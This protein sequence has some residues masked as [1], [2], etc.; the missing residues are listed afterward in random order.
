MGTLILGGSGEADR[1]SRRRFPIVTRS[2]SERWGPGA[3]LIESED[4]PRSWSSSD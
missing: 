1:G 2:W 4:S 3:R